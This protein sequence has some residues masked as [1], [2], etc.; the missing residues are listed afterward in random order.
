MLLDHCFVGQQY[1]PWSSFRGRPHAAL[2]A[3]FKRN[4]RLRFHSLLQVGCDDCRRP[5]TEAGLPFLGQ[6]L[7]NQL[8][9]P[10]EHFLLY[11]FLVRCLLRVVLQTALRLRD[12]CLSHFNDQQ[13]QL[14]EL[15]V[16]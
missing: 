14:S 7:V 4:L 11:N 5:T 2:S 8:R 16:L 13:T 3:L 6:L 15:F 10:I 12:Q 9:L 1:F